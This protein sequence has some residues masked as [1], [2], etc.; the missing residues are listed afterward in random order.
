MNRIPVNIP[1]G[2]CGAFQ[3]KKA[4]G[5]FQNAQ[6]ELYGTV[7]HGRVEEEPHGTYTALWISEHNGSAI[8]GSVMQDNYTEVLEHQPLWDNAFGKI[9]I[10]GLGVGM[11]NEYLVRNPHVTSVT[12]VEKYSEV[13]DLVWNHCAKDS[14]FTLV[15][16]DIETWIPPADSYWD[17]GWFDTWLGINPMSMEEYKQFIVA[18]YSPFCGK[19]ETWKPFNA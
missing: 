2:A 13:I 5:T 3:I 6:A 7:H 4:T 17:Y 14:R 10:G 18:K 9:L 12:I 15:Q 16:A 1:V 11:V 19:V 8:N